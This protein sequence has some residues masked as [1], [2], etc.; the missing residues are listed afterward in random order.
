NLWNKVDKPPKVKGEYVSGGKVDQRFLQTRSGHMIFL[1]DKQ[2][3]EEII[4]QD[5]TK[6]NSLVI[7]ST[8]NTFT[9]KSKGDFTIETQGNF[10]V[11]ATGD[12]TMDAKGNNKITCARAFSVDAK[13]EAS[14]TSTSEKLALKPGA[15]QLAGAKVDIKSNSMLGVSGT[16]MVEIKGA[17]VKIN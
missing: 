9:M 13:Q 2:G 15:T 7:N 14:L 17:L 4:I 1:N 16:A 5:K 3:E 10:I 12:V 11:K 6:E 8:K